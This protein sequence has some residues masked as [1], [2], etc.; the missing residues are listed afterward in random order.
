MKKKATSLRMSAE[1]K[2]S[3]QKK[4]ENMI[5][6]HKETLEKITKQAQAIVTDWDKIKD[7]VSKEKKAAYFGIEDEKASKTGALTSEE[8]KVFAEEFAKIQQ[9]YSPKQEKEAEEAFMQILD[10]FSS[11]E[12]IKKIK[13]AYKAENEEEGKKLLQELL[14]EQPPQGP[15]ILYALLEAI[16][17]LKKGIADFAK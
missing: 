12:T 7:Q 15:A 4:L 10:K 13:E 1:K 9:T 3:Y 6:K 14:G 5:D 8:K 16:E 11:N 2:K 17:K